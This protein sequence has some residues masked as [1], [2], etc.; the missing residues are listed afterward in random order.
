MR[1]CVECPAAGNA[2]T[3]RRVAEVIGVEVPLGAEMDGWREIVALPVPP[4]AAAARS[5]EA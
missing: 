3:N 4:V 1:Q 2:T 5:N